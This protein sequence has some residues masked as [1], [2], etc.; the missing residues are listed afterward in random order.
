MSAGNSLERSQRFARHIAILQHRYEQ[1]LAACKADSVQ[2]LAGLPTMRE[3]DDQPY[4]FR[5]DPYFLQWLPL[6]DAAG[7][8]IEFSPGNR[9]QLLFACEQDFWHAPAQLP[10]D[11]M[12][13]HF[14]VSQ[15]PAADIARRVD[16]PAQATITLG[17]STGRPTSASEPNGEGD[18]E[19][20]LIE[21]LDFDRAIKTEYEIE[22][23][24]IASAAA[25]RGHL[26]VADALTQGRSEFELHVA[27]CA[28]AAQSDIDLP[29]T[30]IVALNE[31][32]AV[33]HYQHHETSA[34]ESLRTLLID[35]G[36]QHNGYAADVT[37]TYGF[38]DAQ[39]IEL[40]ARMDELQQYV[41]AQ[42]FEGADF[43]ALNELTHQLIAAVLEEFDLIT[44]TCETALEKGAT[45]V[46]LPHGLGH[47]LG[48]QVHD[49]GGHASDRS[50]NRRE[51]PSQH[52]FLR[53]TRKL[54]SDMIVTIE[55][56]LYF[57]E[58]L[59][60]RFDRETP[61]LLRRETIERLTPYGGI[62]IEDDVRVKSRGHDNLTR[63][64]LGAQ[65]F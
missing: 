28:A 65:G 27:Y 5:A 19:S 46:F 23:I 11:D 59:I 34:P 10:P 40:I 9:P 1:A 18:R 31:H 2:I 30:S 50:G 25:A 22:C 3:R 53:L 12:L 64:A 49:V 60:E 63:A 33:L 26:A 58:A 21:F 47:L 41:C 29:Y 36:A 8:V 4:P 6:P 52:P 38:G 14:D 57:I 35:A 56:G 15:M 20:A 48:L 44:C 32:A 16:T 17:K 24:E 61:G 43:V 45:R 42:V 54:A 13:E 55:P 39:F 7:S 37:R 62:R 51:P